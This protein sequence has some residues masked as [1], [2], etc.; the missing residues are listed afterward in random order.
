MWHKGR[1]GPG[2]HRAGM[3]GRGDFKYVILELL[4]EKP[5]HGYEIIRAVEGRFGG[6]Y[7]P[8]PGVVYPTL[9]MLE[10][11]G[12]VTSQEQDGKKVYTITEEG[13]KYLAEQKDVVGEIRDRIK[14]HW[15]F[16]TNRDFH[17]TMHAF[18]DLGRILGARANGAGPAKLAR[19]RQVIEKARQDVESILQE[20]EKGEAQP[21]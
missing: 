12:Y 4:A 8:S 16:V 11:L 10:D 19:V 14:S 1:F 9:Q 5:R 17:E 2:F 3:F 6:F 15:G 13:R 18:G 7:S 20:E 21:G